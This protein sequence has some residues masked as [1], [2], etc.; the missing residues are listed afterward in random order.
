VA[1]EA[2]STTTRSTRTGGRVLL[3]ALAV[4]TFAVGYLGQGGWRIGT[5]TAP[6]VSAIVTD[7]IGG[8]G[9]RHPARV[10]VSIS[11]SNDGTDEIQVI[12][13]MAA[14]QG[15]SVLSLAPA[16]LVVPAGESA[17]LNANVAVDCTLPSPL[18]LPAFGL[19]LINGDQWQLR[20]GGSGAL[21]EACGRAVPK[22]RPLAVTAGR[23][24]N[25][26]LALL[27]RSP[28]GRPLQITAIRAGG[29]RLA[30][31]ALPARVTGPAPVVVW[32]DPPPSCPMQWRVAGLPDALGFDLMPEAGSGPDSVTGWISELDLSIGPALIS[33]LLATSCA[34]S[35]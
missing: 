35:G 20:I 31:P 16:A 34:V 7:V 33:W 10:Q 28:T 17:L 8:A 25:G 6:A 29:V 32:L 19:K 30:A 26:R 3:G 22:I 12:K 21:L 18:L 27:V 2:R 1:E 9:V 15:T 24:T 11:V 5:P 13:P 14:G 4:L 23:T